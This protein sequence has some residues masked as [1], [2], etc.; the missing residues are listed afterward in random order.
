MLVSPA[1]APLPASVA[2]DW[3]GEVGFATSAGP[4]GKTVLVRPDA[5][6][7]WATSDQSA[8]SRDAEIRQALA[9][10]CGPATAEG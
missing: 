6:I 2:D 1:D 9:R 3:S 8:E 7:A 5:C 4:T 10:N